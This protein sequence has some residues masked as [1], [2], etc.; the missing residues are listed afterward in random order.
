M[1]S[2]TFHGMMPADTPTGSLRT[3]T[4]PSA[5]GRISSNGKVSARSAQPSSAMVELNT[6]PMSDQLDGVPISAVKTSASSCERAWMAWDSR[7][8]VAARSAPLSCG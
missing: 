8:T 4:G 2:G 5:P 1:N 3:S 6:W 7:R